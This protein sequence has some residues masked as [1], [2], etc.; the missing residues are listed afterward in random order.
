MG[1]Q[2]ASYL[3]A[4]AWM[5]ASGS[6][7]AAGRQFYTTILRQT[8]QPNES[9][10]S[11]GAGLQ[12]TER[13][14]ADIAADVIELYTGYQPPGVGGC[15][16]YKVGPLLDATHLSPEEF[17]HA[18]I[19]PYVKIVRFRER[20]ETGDDIAKLMF[21]E[22][23]MDF[24][25]DRATRRALLADGKFPVQFSFLP[26]G[27]R[28]LQELDTEVGPIRGRMSINDALR[29]FIGSDDFMIRWITDGQVEPR[30]FPSVM[31]LYE[32]KLLADMSESVCNFG[33]KE[34]G[35]V[36]VTKSRLPWGSM[37]D[38]TPPTVL[39]RTEIEN[40]GKDNLPDLLQQLSQ[41]AFHRGLGYRPSGTQCA[42]LRGV[43]PVKVLINGRPM[44]GSAADFFE[45]TCIDLNNIPLSAVERI[46]V[47]PDAV[48][49]AHGAD[50]LGGAINL[51]LKKSDT[52]SADARYQGARGGAGL[53][54]TSIVAGTSEDAWLA[55][56]VLDYSE[57]SSLQGDERE[58]WRNQD[59]RRFGGLDYRSSFSAPP[60]VS[61]LDGGSLASLNS[62]MA[63]VRVS[64]AGSIDFAAGEQNQSSLYAWQDIVPAIRRM[65]VSAMAE[66]EVGSALLRS[67]FLLAD[68]SVTHQY[69]PEV[70]PGLVLGEHHYQNPFGVPV[71]VQAALTGLPSPQTEVDS[72][73]LRGVL[74]IDGRWSKLDYSIYALH[75][76]EDAATTSS[77]WVD[78]GALAESLSGLTPS[79]LNVLTDR[80]GLGGSYILSPASTVRSV[81]GGTI[82]SASVRGDLF[83]MPGGSAS[84][85]IGSEVWRE[86]G[87]YGNVTAKL[88]RQ[89][90]SGF[91]I[92]Q[93]PIVEGVKATF[94]ARLDDYEKLDPVTSYQY[95]LE[96]KPLHRLRLSAS[97]SDT[98]AAPRMF[99]LH[100]P[101]QSTSTVILDPSWG[102][103]V[104]VTIVFGGNEDLRPTIGRSSTFGLAFGTPED[105]FRASIDLW[106]V[107]LQDRSAVV[108]P[109]T[110]LAY[111]DT[112]L[113]GRVV[114]DPATADDIAAGRRGRL[115]T[116]DV[117]R[118]NFGGTETR[119]ID[120]SI[121]NTF[122]T[123]TARVTP[124]LDITYT[125]SFRYADIPSV[126]DPGRERTGVADVQGTITR[127]RLRG[128]LQ[129]AMAEW[130]TNILAR[131]NS[132]YEDVDAA[133]AA[134][135]RRVCPGMIVDF[136]LAKEIGEHLK[137]TVGASDIFDHSPSFSEVFG[138]AGYDLSQDNLV[139]RTA[140]VTL[141]VRL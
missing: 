136:N 30:I 61:S 55:S 97:Y 73:L 43:A 125:D 105:A 19:S 98:F 18:L 12:L 44:F 62:S 37:A 127:W 78:Y 35:R 23:E 24:S 39:D 68:R 137:V 10:G 108:F 75:S 82:F 88:H 70:I 3:V 45:D 92:F 58:R 74:Q 27:G 138:T 76:I 17:W 32:E 110:L 60:N 130:D 95:S 8:P 15:G 87:D 71:A 91:G 34:L 48:S 25:V 83:N 81:I 5:A 11:I 113:D 96:W 139:G 57:M 4:A 66:R 120:A 69:A 132:C 14:S 93:L 122:K 117:R 29:I 114:R 141:S 124:R 53:L 140:F 59:F 116:L 104:P 77:N 36:T 54:H 85:Q 79:Q 47:S 121:S 63:A 118:A 28:E 129:I 21:G 52:Q 64:P 112:A 42:V 41:S 20:R 94:G 72:T 26:N 99:D 1:T 101:V 80:P 33:Y 111:E 102:E 49:F 38:T 56:L 2:I 90:V 135:G 84:A 50:A 13:V 109:V 100:F 16:S 46:E 51:V 67:E 31:P 131:W 106:S 9:G 115:R 40:S 119:G 126:R 6:G 22:N 103:I 134:T 107:S 7:S 128:W 133:V 89:I 65:N 123:E 86:F